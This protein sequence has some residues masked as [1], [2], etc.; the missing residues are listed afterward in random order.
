MNTE[1][2]P[3]LM[4]LM[5]NKMI[6]WTLNSAPWY[7]WY[8]WI[9]LRWHEEQCPPSSSTKHFVTLCRTSCAVLLCLMLFHTNTMIYDVSV[10]WRTKYINVQDVQE[11]IDDH[12]LW[13]LENG[14]SC[15]LIYSLFLCSSALVFLCYVVLIG[16][17][18]P[19]NPWIETD[20]DVSPPR[21]LW[22][23]AE[24]AASHHIV[25]DDH[26][27]SHSLTWP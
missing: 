10:L 17:S 4:I 18:G 12:V 9:I 15:A 25:L 1:Q 19:F 24:P 11:S 26:R 14:C 13:C 20:G 5:N 7:W 2:Y 3:L 27:P 8:W 22:N 16:H 23:K 6:W 21:H